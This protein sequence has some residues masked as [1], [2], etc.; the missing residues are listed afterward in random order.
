LLQDL[1]VIEAS[2]AQYNRA[3]AGFSLWAMAGRAE[4]LTLRQQRSEP[5]AEDYDIAFAFYGISLVQFE[6]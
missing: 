6:H 2:N 1:L 4:R 5:F 3:E